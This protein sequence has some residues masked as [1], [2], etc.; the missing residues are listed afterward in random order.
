VKIAVLP[1]LSKKDAQFHTERL[2]H[3]LTDCKAEVV[4]GC[5]MQELFSKQP[6]SFEPSFTKMI[7]DCDAVIAVGGDGTIIHAAKHAAVAHKPL[8]GVN[9]GRLGFVA[10]LEPDEFDKLQ[11]LVNGN[12]RLEERMLLQVEVGTGENRRTYYALNDAVISRGSLS[13]IIDLRVC[14]NDNRICDYRADGL[15]FATPTGS[16]AYSLAAGGPV[17]DPSLDCIL[18]TPICPHSV[19]SRTVAFSSKS[20]LSVQASCRGGSEIILTVD[21]EPPL[22]LN[23]G[24]IVEIRASNLKVNL[25]KLKQQDFY[26]ILSE[27]L[28]ERRI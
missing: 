16:T 11:Y 9:L 18:L 20:R 25:I 13:R 26:D 22:E 24:D 3:K 2:I 27:K 14:L 7:N 19:F 17:M 21:G 10:G 4:M 1:N 28:T 8:L 12:Y 23:S 15:I 6:V 5:D